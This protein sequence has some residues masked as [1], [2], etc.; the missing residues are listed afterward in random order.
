M[1]IMTQLAISMT[2]NEKRWLD[3]WATLSG[4]TTAE[5]GIVEVLKTCGGLPRKEAFWTESFPFAE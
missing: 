4:Y 2:A 5:E 3:D 1:Q